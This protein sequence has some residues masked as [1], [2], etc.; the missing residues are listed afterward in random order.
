MSRTPVALL[1]LLLA[2]AALAG[3]GRQP[4]T[5]APAPAATTAAAAPAALPH[6]AVV[7]YRDATMDALGKHM[8]ALGMIAK[9]EVNRPG[10]VL[11]HAAALKAGA[12]DLT[13]LFP[14]GSG[15]EAYKTG[16]KAEIWT[17]WG[18]FEAAAATF[19]TAT[20]A[21]EEAARA[22]D[23]EAVK[24]RLGAVGE[25]CGGCHEPFKSDD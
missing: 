7:A 2:T 10:D 21:L 17:Q 16:A 9:G 14:A 25:A 3:P 5:P 22:G 24:A 23:M 4:A 15:S 18:D 6:K 12:T 20:T 1:S 19:L 13:S 11:G 8:K